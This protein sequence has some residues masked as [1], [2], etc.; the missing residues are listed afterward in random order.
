MP[1]C[2][3]QSNSV[4]N[5]NEYQQSSGEGIK[6]WGGQY[7]PHLWA[8]FVQNVE[9]RR[10]TTLW[11]STTCYGDSLIYRISS[12]TARTAHYIVSSS[13]A[14]IEECAGIT[15]LHFR[16]SWRLRHSYPLLWNS[17]NRGCW[18][19]ERDGGMISYPWKEEQLSLWKLGSLKMLLN[20]L[21]NRVVVLRN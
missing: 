8:D 18:P 19:G 12:S 1:H 2:D 4:S 17:W 6:A 13:K 3:P 11:V 15:A 20:D 21:T 9:P 7:H 16:C 10:L 14:I 5:R